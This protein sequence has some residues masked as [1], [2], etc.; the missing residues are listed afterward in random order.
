MSDKKRT[1][2][3]AK[4][5]IAGIGMFFLMM[6]CIAK[7]EHEADI[8]SRTIHK[9]LNIKIAKTPQQKAKQAIKKPQLKPARHVLVADLHKEL[10]ITIHGTK[11]WFILLEDDGYD[12]TQV[13]LKLIYK[14][15]P[16]YISTVAKDTMR[17]A[18]A[19]LDVLLKHDR[20]LFNDHIALSVWARFYKKGTTGQQLGVSYG[21]TYYDR[22]TDSLAWKPYKK[23][24]LF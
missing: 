19:A 21:R 14:Y 24:W 12:R 16:K 22:T 17:V 8:K 18:Q 7:F 9:K 1:P 3:S 4:I 5:L 6:L 13:R 15:Q 20:D 2:R 11:R 23:G 10:G